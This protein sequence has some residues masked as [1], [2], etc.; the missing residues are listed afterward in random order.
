MSCS[1][2]VD[3]AAIKIKA[4]DFLQQADDVGVATKYRANRGGNFAGRKSCGGDLIEQGLK[5]VMV[6]AVDDGDLDVAA[7]SPRAALSPPK[8]APT[9]DHPGRALAGGRP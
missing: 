6:L 9:I 8:P 3:D 4:L 5:G 7:G 1:R 2:G